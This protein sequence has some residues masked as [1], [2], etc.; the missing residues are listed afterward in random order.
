MIQRTVWTVPLILVLIAPWAAAAGPSVARA[1][2][3]TL[4]IPTYETP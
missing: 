1:K 2:A 3:A 4:V